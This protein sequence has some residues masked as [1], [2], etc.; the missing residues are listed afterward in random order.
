VCNTVR[1]ASC[2]VVQPLLSKVSLD[3]RK[4]AEMA[5]EVQ[6]GVLEEAQR[7][8]HVGEMVIVVCSFQVPARKSVC[9]FEGGGLSAASCTSTHCL[10]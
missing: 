10:D 9:A 4:V 8:N 3:A 6:R 7:G 1:I 2:G 5:V